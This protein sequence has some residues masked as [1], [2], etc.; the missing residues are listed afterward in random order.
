[1][2]SK[3]AVELMIW[4]EIFDRMEKCCDACEHVANAVESIIMKN[5]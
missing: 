4:R 2:S 5:T 1:M 3:D